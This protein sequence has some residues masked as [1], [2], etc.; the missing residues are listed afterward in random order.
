MNESTKGL[1]VLD[2]Q[3]LTE[4]PVQMIRPIATPEEAFQAWKAFQDLK[5]RLV[6]DDDLQNVGGKN[7]IK[8]SGWRKI[9]AAFGLDT[10]LLSERRMPNESGVGFTVE[11]TVRA[12]APNGRHADGVGSFDSTERKMT[13]PE[14][15]VR[16][17]A[18][19]RAANRAI[20][21][22]VGGGEV[23]AEEMG[24]RGDG[25]EVAELKAQIAQLQAPIPRPEAEKMCAEFGK[26]LAAEGI[27]TTPENGPSILLEVV[28]AR[29]DLRRAYKALKATKPAESRA[30]A[31]ADSSGE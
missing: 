16:A 28:L 13:H 30:E 22:L 19:T 23:S 1:Q 10:E 5:K 3:V 24:E 2:G 12:I 4:R 15:D 7:A 8:K 29:G 26:A 31:P 21:D 6:T 17:T 18:Y 14:H 25:K 9:A 27:S 20:S 11:C